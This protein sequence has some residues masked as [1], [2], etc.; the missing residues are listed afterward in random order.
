MAP[1]P[2]GVKEPRSGGGLSRLWG[3]VAAWA[4]TLVALGAVEGPFPEKVF[5]IYLGAGAASLLILGN[6][7]GGLLSLLKLVRGNL[8][9]RGER[10]TFDRFGPLLSIDGGIYVSLWLVTAALAGPGAA[11]VASQLWVIPFLY[12]RWMSGA[13]PRPGAAAWTATAMAALG[14]A[15][16]GASGSELNLWAAIP[17]ALALAVQNALHYERN[18]FW[19]QRVVP[20]DDPL[21][22]AAAALGYNTVFLLVSLPV[23]AAL[24]H[25]GGYGVG[26]GG[27]LLL[28]AAG[29]VGSFGSWWFR[30]GNLRDVERPVINAVVPVHAGAAA[31]ALD[32]LGYGGIASRPLFWAGAAL[33]LGGASLASWLG[34]RRGDA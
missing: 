19:A 8:I 27:F 30:S 5:A 26:A 28:A 12:L 23:W 11:A 24:A 33:A 10:R 16:V 3:A 7:S 34:M 22:R 9:L 1:Q 13:A 6:R 21:R 32:V 20:S 14:A 31:L 25:R 4:A 17:A 29:G 18:L 15:A 2:P